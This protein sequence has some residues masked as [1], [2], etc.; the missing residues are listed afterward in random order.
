MKT[1]IIIA[2]P[3]MISLSNAAH[4]SCATR[5]APQEERLILSEDAQQKIC[6]MYFDNINGIRGR[7]PL[8]DKEQEA[9]PLTHDNE[10]P[11][12]GDARDISAVLPRETS[13]ECGY[14]DGLGRRVSESEYELELDYERE[15]G[16]PYPPHLRPE[17][18]SL[19]LHAHSDAQCSGD[20]IGEITQPD[21]CYPVAKGMGVSVGSLPLPRNC[22]VLGYEG[23]ACDGEPVEVVPL[24]RRAEGG[25]F[26]PF[27]TASAADRRTFGSVL[28]E[29]EP[30]VD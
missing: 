11:D 23:E 27:G 17:A 25:C 20:T 2:L 16:V 24:G 29:C 3:A 13:P 7:A 26:A 9:Q 15:H 14:Y 18:G 19:S 12:A 28:V 30:L 10:W 5:E 4:F 8:P 21:V 22:E 1:L 6:A